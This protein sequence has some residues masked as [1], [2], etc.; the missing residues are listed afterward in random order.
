MSIPVTI[1]DL[2]DRLVEYGS[3]CFLVSVG[4]D[5]AP[6]VVHVPV[7]W[8]GQ[9]LACTPGRGTCRNLA[10]SPDGAPVTLVF[11][12]PQT[13]FHSM[14]LDGVGQVVGT[15]RVAIEVTGGVLHRPAPPMPGD[16][17]SC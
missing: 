16:T 1:D 8:D 17:A 12:G 5:G 6:K 15:D 13:D 4:S 11:P 14:L 7:E 9:T 3:D 10:A 2:P